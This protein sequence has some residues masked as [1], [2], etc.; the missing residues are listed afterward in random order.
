[1]ETSEILTLIGLGFTIVGAIV[2]S[3]WQ[4]SG[5][6]SG[7]SSSIA[8]LTRRVEK[9]DQHIEG[10]SEHEREQDMRITLLEAMVKD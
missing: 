4:I 1:M 7:I 10:I 9:I 3:A 2:G 6:L 5:K 8:T